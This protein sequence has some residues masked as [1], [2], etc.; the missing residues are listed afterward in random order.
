[1]RRKLFCCRPCHLPSPS[2]PSSSLTLIACFFLAPPGSLLVLPIAA[3]PTGTVSGAAHQ[4][5]KPPVAIPGCQTLLASSI[6]LRFLHG[7]P[8]LPARP[9]P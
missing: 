9:S 6:C 2:L 4:H 1:M 5:S 3:P 7:W 8:P